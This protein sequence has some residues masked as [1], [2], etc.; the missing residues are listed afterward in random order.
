MNVGAIAETAGVSRA[1][2]YQY[3]ES[4]EQLLVELVREAADELLLVV[5]RI[6]L[7]GP[8]SDGYANLRKW[9][10][11]WACVQDTYKALYLQ[12][13]LVDASQQSLRPLLAEYIVSY[14]TT[15]TSGLVTATRE[16][17][18][19]VDGTATVILALLFRIN[20][21]RQK[22]INR[23]LGDDQVL[24]AIA[25]FVQLA[26]F[27]STVDEAIPANQ[28]PTRVITTTEHRGSSVRTLVPEVERSPTLQRILDAAAETFAARGYYATTIRDVLHT[29]AAGRGTF[30][31]HFRD[32][33]DLLVILSQDML[34]R[35]E[36]LAGG[37]AAAIHDDDQPGAIQ[38][39]LQE[40]ITLHRRYRGV[41]RA[42]DQGA[43]SY[44]QLNELRMQSGAAILHTFDEAL[45]SVD[46]THP[47][48]VRVGSLLLLALLERGADYVFGTP[49]DLDPQRVIDVVTRLIESGL[50]DRTPT[51]RP[52]GAG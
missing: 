17:P 1:T 4:K 30:Y 35:L 37:F 3:F 13:A 20:E 41:F 24:N 40:C 2:F 10:G 18:P 9:I 25:T 45:T 29:A 14:V 39:W 46:R 6:G 23:G 47:F 34:A 43:A 49:Y 32:K 12:W 26:L 7:F 19:D 31:R 52:T 51:K 33:A 22:G 16:V 44:S 5:R 28:P 50:L 11:E 15:L 42:L 8:T 48:D 38:G 27:P 21:Y 36:E